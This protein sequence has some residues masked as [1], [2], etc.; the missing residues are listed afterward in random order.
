MII[1]LI[2]LGEH[3]LYILYEIN[4][5]PNN[6]TNSNR[7]LNITDNIGF[8]RILLIRDRLDD[9]EEI[10]TVIQKSNINF[11]N[12]QIEEFKEF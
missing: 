10:L 9:L 5:Y 1:H 12:Y 4:Q 3:K 8:K 2:I 11:N 7:T 6:S